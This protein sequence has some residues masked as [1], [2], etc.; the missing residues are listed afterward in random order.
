MNWSQ[1]RP[2]VRRSNWGRARSGRL[3]G[4]RITMQ[5]CK[6]NPSLRVTT[7]CG[8]QLCEDTDAVAQQSPRHAM[9]TRK[10]SHREAPR[11]V[12]TATRMSM[13]C[14]RSTTVP[15]TFSR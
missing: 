6:P 7:L 8:G 3:A 5:H 9:R 12:L 11:A 10:R 13:C 15:L 14:G 1:S 2:F 4:L